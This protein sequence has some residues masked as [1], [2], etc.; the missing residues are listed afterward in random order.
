VGLPADLLRRRPDIR[1]AEREL[2]A[3]TADIGVAVAEQ[4][5]RLVLVGSG[6]WD[7]IHAGNLTAAASRFW[8]VGPQLSLPLFTGGRLKNQVTA[9]EAARDARWRLI[10]RKC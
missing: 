10:G 5:P 3:A 7:S 9:R 1:Q 8:N 6:G 2:A 4:Y